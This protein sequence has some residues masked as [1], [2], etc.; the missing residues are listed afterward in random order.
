MIDSTQRSCSVLTLECRRREVGYGKALLVMRRNFKALN[1]KYQQQVRELDHIESV[2]SQ[3]E[4]SK[5][6][7]AGWHHQ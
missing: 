2:I 5:R 7:I 1:N 3:W 4:K 6:R